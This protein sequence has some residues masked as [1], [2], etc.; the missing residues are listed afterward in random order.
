MADPGSR[1]VFF[2]FHYDRDIF[3]VQQ[4]KNHYITK[5]GYRAAG[6]FDGSLAELART[7]GKTAVKR[8]INKGLPGS[9]VTCVLIGNET[10]RRHWV[11]YEIF[12]SIELGM[13]LI[14]IRIHQLQNPKHGVDTA[15]GNPF[16]Y[17][18]L[19]RQRP[20]EYAGSIRKIYFRLATVRRR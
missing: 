14:G 4:I 9:S 12:R 13:G 11:D 6:Y 3:R 18:G 1:S 15:G 7:E 2:S 20:E 19:R 5:L 17:L 10:F 16:D 8:A